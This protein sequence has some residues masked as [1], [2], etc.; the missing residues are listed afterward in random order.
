MGT[1]IRGPFGDGVSGFFAG[2]KPL[3]PSPNG[4]SMLLQCRNF[5]FQMS[6]V[7]CLPEIIFA[8]LSADTTKAYGREMKHFLK[9]KECR[10]YM[11][12]CRE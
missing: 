5:H 2:K 4:P 8:M 7:R 9:K 3:T 11:K 10:M 12:I 1:E 6:S